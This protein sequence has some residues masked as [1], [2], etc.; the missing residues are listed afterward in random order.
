MHQI[1]KLIGKLWKCFLKSNKGSGNFLP[2]PSISN[3]NSENL[4]M[5]TKK[6]VICKTSTLVLYPNPDIELTKIII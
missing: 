4:L 1:I 6:N 5:M 2:L 3:Q